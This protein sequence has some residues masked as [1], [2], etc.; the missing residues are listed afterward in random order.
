MEHNLEIP[1]QGNNAVKKAGQ[2]KRAEPGLQS[3]PMDIE[4]SIRRAG[5]KEF[6]LEL[7]EIYI[8]ETGHSLAQLKEAVAARNAAQI[9][10]IAHGIKG[11]SAEML[12]EPLRQSAC[13]L[14]IA[15]RQNELENIENLLGS[16]K[17]EY[18]RLIL[19]V[20]LV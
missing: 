17:A 9:Q 5:D 12:A 1:S 8:E 13:N 10:R 4:A 19:Q 3:T 18:A 16:I 11:S 2:P 20:E 15:G 14:E 7:V 6:W